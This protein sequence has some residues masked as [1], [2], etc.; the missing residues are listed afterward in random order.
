MWI[1]VTAVSTALIFS[2]ICSIS[3]S[4]LLSISHGQVES[5][6]RQGRKSGALLRDFKRNIDVPI[7]A[8]LIVNTIAHTIGAS[9]AGATYQNVFDPSTL[10]I[11]TIVFTIAVLLFTE[12]I[13][14][15][16]GVT[17]ASQLAGPVARGIQ[18]MTILLRPLVVVSEAISR[19]LRGNREV[20]VTS[21]EEIRL[22]AA[23]GRNEGVVGVRTAGMIIGATRL[24]QLSAEDVMVHR[25]SVVTLSTEY[26]REE[27]LQVLKTSGHSRFPLTEGDD[28]DGVIGV[29][30]A[31]ELLYWMQENE[32]GPI[33]WKELSRDLVSV[34]DGQPL[35]RLLRTFQESR[36][37]LA[38]VVNEYGESDGIVTL[39]DVIEEIVGEIIDEQDKP[40][41]EFSQRGDGSIECRG[42]AELR[43]IAAQLGLAHNVPDDVTTVGGLLSEHLRRVPKPGDEMEWHGYLISV[44][45]AGPRRV[46]RVRIRP[47]NPE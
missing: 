12:I 39:E 27:V 19:R 28:L 21:A 36:R 8:I 14:K 30:L 37:H 13:P 20:P 34:P 17:F 1:F 40:L 2:F 22:L 41:P 38:I 16:L 23:L 15:T 5:L 32:D 46:D 18:I 3:E 10:W 26:G 42:S 45:R 35:E 47:L 9:V 24:R 31:K 33:P 29:V 6:A 7:A 44:T 25:Q 4:V 43:K 11:F